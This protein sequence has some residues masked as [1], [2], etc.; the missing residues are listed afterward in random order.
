MQKV[1]FRQTLQK[2]KNRPGKAP[3]AVCHYVKVFRAHISK[4]SFITK[5]HLHQ[6]M[7]SLLLTL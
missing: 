6:F 1:V 2:K 5:S 7:L 4:F 3:T